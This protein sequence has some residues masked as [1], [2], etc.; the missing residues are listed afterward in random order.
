L[1]ESDGRDRYLTVALA[2]RI[3]L[4]RQLV[5]TLKIISCFAL[6]RDPRARAAL[7]V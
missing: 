4:V 6:F 1:L 3:F 5:E 7:G 2:S